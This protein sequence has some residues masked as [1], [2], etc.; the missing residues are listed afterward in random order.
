MIE[1]NPVY[2]TEVTEA[3]GDVSLVFALLETPFACAQE[4]AS[5]L[6]ANGWSDGKVSAISAEEYTQ[7]QDEFY[8]L[9]PPNYNAEVENLINQ[10]RP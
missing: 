1:S 2:L 8:G 3:D 10:C 9:T 5:G 4:F 6:K 7:R